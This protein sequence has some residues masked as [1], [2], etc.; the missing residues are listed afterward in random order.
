M[1]FYISDKLPFNTGTYIYT[2]SVVWCVPSFIY[3]LNHMYEIQYYVY[4]TLLL[5][6]MNF[7]FL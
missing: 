4:I 3:D 2:T 7:Y 1:L 5:I 6:S